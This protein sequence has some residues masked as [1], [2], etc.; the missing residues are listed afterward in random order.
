MSSI[1][2]AEIHPDIT[3]VLVDDIPQEGE[4]GF[5]I[6]SL[7]KAA[8]A[9]RKYI[10]A[11][12]RM[13][14]RWDQAK[15]F[16]E[17][18]DLWYE[19]ANVEDENTMSYMMGLLKPYISREVL[20]LRKGKTVKAPGV[21]ITLRKKPNRVEVVDEELAIKFCEANQPQIVQVKKSL[22]KSEINKLLSQG[23]LIPGVN[24]TI[25]EEELQI[26]EK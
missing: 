16:K 1:A 19:R 8:W 11:K 5:V 21:N 14:E 7:E 17:K 2:V 26:K 15:G 18:I 13:T 3:E 22:S 23:E 10:Q 4:E 25:G 20:K 24:V 9:A 12:E 6:D